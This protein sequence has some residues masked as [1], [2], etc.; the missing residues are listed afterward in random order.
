MKTST[1]IF[2]FLLFI[3]AGKISAMEIY[4]YNKGI[5]DKVTFTAEQEKKI[6]EIVKDIYESADKTSSYNISKENIKEI[7]SKDRCV[8][9][10]FDLSNMYSNGAIGTSIVRKMLIPISGSYAAEIK[11]G[12]LTFFV[13]EDAGKDA[14]KYKY[15]GKSYSNSNGFKYIEQLYKALQR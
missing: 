13:G 6:K 15:N 3:F 12:N 4:I 11:K 7:K 14:D 2:L 9:I 10:I 5:S 1:L 8:E